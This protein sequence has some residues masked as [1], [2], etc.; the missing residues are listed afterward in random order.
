MCFFKFW[1][2]FYFHI[3]FNP[4]LLS[5]QLKTK[6]GKNSRSQETHTHTNT[7]TLKELLGWW[8]G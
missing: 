1:L 8:W 2:C 7:D 4:A 5:F 6:L 3:D